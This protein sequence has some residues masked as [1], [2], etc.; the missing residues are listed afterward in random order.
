MSEQARTQYFQAM[1]AIE[2]G[3]PRRALDLLRRA[4]LLATDDPQLATRILAEMVRV[5]PQA[6]A[7]EEQA[8]WQQQLTRLQTTIGSG[9]EGPPEDAGSEKTRWMSR[10]GRLLLLVASVIAILAIL[11]YGGCK[12]WEYSA[13]RYEPVTKG[14]PRASEGKRR[15]AET[16]KCGTEGN[17]GNGGGRIS[18]CLA[19]AAGDPIRAPS[20]KGG[21]EREKSFDPVATAPQPGVSPFSSEMASAALMAPGASPDVHRASRTHALGPP[22][23]DSRAA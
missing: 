8:L 18:R 5:A 6:G 16:P 23:A 1:T 9:S 7:M 15:N 17:G 12:F 14:P 19:N 13:R 11:G 20:R 21:V 22:P 2:G 10:T 3:D 4:R